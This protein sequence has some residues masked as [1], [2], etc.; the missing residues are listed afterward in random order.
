VELQ[1]P[2][3]EPQSAASSQRFRLRNLC[4][5]EQIAIKAPRAILLTP[6]HRNLHMI[7]PKYVSH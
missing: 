5:P 1:L 6:R 3:L 7:K 4:E 2:A